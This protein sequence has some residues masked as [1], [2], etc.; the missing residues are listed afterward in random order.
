RVMG[1]TR[2]LIYSQ[3]LMLNLVD[4]GLEREEA[5]KIVQESSMKVWADQNLDLKTM[6]KNDSRVNAKLTD[7]EIDSIFDPAYFL[8]NVGAI[9]KRLG[10]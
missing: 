6:M 10:L 4:K 5:Y 2:G 3:R 7:Q 9:Y 1:T 8:R